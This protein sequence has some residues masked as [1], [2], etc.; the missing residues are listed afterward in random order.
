MGDILKLDKKNLSQLDPGGVLKSSHDDLSQS[1]R[2]VNGLSSVPSSYSRVQLTYNGSGSVTKAVFYEGTLARITDILCQAD[3]AG[4]LNNTYFT[5]ASENNE[6]RYFIWYNVDGLGVAPVVANHFGIEVSIQS[7]DAAPIVSLATEIALRNITDF[8]V[9]R[10]DKRLVIENVRKGASDATADFGTGFTIIATQVGTERITKVID[11]PFDGNTKYLYNTQEKRFTVE[12]INSIQAQV[13]IDAAD[14]DNIAISAHENPRNILFTNI[15]AA[16]GLSTSAYT[17]VLSYTA[18]EDIQVRVIRIK[19]DTFGAFRVKVDG[20]IKD[21]FQT[22]PLQR[23]CVFEFSEEE[24][25]TTGQAVTIE[26]VPDR[27][28]NIV[29]YDFFGRIEAY[30]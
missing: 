8:Y 3:S 20:T 14:G 27:I 19:A 15:I 2:T 13:E 22:S 4:S 29:N 9:Q 16:A 30:A 18:I 10:I 7:N 24:S 26:F 6:S 17:Q 5:I 25:V 12:S 11:I 23:N 21:Y 28:Q 1:L